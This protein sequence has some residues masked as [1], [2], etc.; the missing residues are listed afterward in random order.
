MVAIRSIFFREEEVFLVG[1]APLKRFVRLLETSS[2]RVDAS[3]VAEI[4]VIGLLCGASF[5]SIRSGVR[6]SRSS[7]SEADGLSSGGGAATD[8]RSIARPGV[9]GWGASL[10]CSNAATN[11]RTLG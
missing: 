1:E 6:V 4:G 7:I 5:V 3:A 8:S 9:A 11:A 2:G 10:A